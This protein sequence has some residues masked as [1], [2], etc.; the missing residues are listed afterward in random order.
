MKNVLKGLVALCCAVLGVEAVADGAS[1]N[2]NVIIIY[3]DDHGVTDLGLHGIDP[4]VD[5][6]TLDTLASGGALMTSGYASAPKC[7]PSRA[8]LMMGR[9]QNEVGLIINTDGPLPLT[10]P[11]GDPIVLIPERMRDLGYTTGQVGK[12]HLGDEGD[13]FTGAR[14]FDEYYTG[15]YT[16]YEVNFDLDGNSVP[17]QDVSHMRNRVTV[18]GEAAEA[19]I[20]RNH[21][22]EFFLYLAFYGPHTPRISTNDSYYVNFPELDYPNY[23]DEMD[24]I[25]RQGLALI[26]AIDDSVDGVMQKLREH[27]IEEDTL[28]FFAGDNGA[29]PKFGTDIGGVKSLETADGSE[30][31]PL[32]GEKGTLWEGGIRVPMFAYWKDTIPPGLVIDEPVSTLDFTATTLIAGG[33]TPTAEMDG[34]NLLPRLTNGAPT[35][36]RDTPLFW[37]HD[38]AIAIRKGDWKLQRDATADYLFNLADDPWELTNLRYQNPAK[39]AELVADLLAWRDSLPPEGQSTLG[40]PRGP[41]YVNGAPVGTAIE[42][43]YVIPYTNA[44]PAAYPVAIE[45]PGEPAL[46][47]DGDGML[48]D[49]EFAAGRDMNDASDLAFEFNADGDYQGW[50]SVMASISNATVTSGILS[51]QSESKSGRIESDD[52]SF[53]SGALSNLLV[54]VKSDASSTLTLR[55]ATSSNDV[56]DNTRK[57]AIPYSSGQFET[58]ILPLGGNPDWDG[59]T[60][61]RMRIN[62]CNGLGNF[63]IDWVRASDGDYDNDSLSDIYEQAN[64]LDPLDPSDGMPDTGGVSFTN[65]LIIFADDLGYGD[66]GCYGA[67][68]IATPHIDSLAANGMRFTQA[69]T[70]SSTCSQSRVSLFSGRY[71]WRSPLHPPTGVIHPAGP[72]ALLERGVVALPTLFQQKGYNTAAFGKWHLGVGYGDSYG[73]RYDWSQPTIEGGPLDVGFNHFFGLAANVLNEPD[74]YIENDKFYGR[75][76]NDVVTVN[77][78]N[79]V[80]PWSEDVRFAQDEVAGDTLAKAVEYIESAPTNEPLFLFFSST[81]PHKPITPAAEFIGSSGIGLYGDF[82]H[83]LDGQ[84]GA[85]LDAFRTT[86][87][88]DDTLVIFTSDNG[89]VI[90][91]SEASAIQWG[92]EPMWEA[93][94]AGHLS[95]G[96]LRGG[97]HA[98][99]EGGSRIPF[100][101]SWSNHIPANITDDR[102]FCLTDVMATCADLLDVSAPESAVDSL[103]FLPVW[104][105]ESAASPRDTVLT[106]SPSAIY[107]IR[108]EKW[109]YIEHDPDNPTGRVTENADQLYDLDLDPGESDNL[110]DQHPEIVAPLKDALIPLKA[111]LNEGIPFVVAP[112]V[113]GSQITLRHPVRQTYRYDILTSE[114]LTDP[115]WQEVSVELAASNGL[116][117]IVVEM[118]D[119]TNRFYVVKESSGGIGVEVWNDSFG[120]SLNTNWTEYLQG[121]GAATTPTGGQLVMDVGIP[122]GSAQ[123]A[124][125]TTV[126]QD[127]DVSMFNGAKL[128]NFYDHPVSARFD[129]ASI[130]GVN[131]GGRN[132]F[133]FSIGD[134]AAGKFNPQANALDDG[135]GFRLE[136]QG[137]P[138]SW[139]IIYQALQGAS[140][141][142]ATVANLNGLPST[143]TFTLDGTQAVIEL[144]GTT[145]TGGDSVLT[146]TLADYSANISGYTLAF[147]AL[148]YGTVTEKTVVTLDAVSVEVAE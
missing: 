107:S 56:M 8:G 104:T 1:R 37:D 124:L 60:I 21:T 29:C 69:Y 113:S 34:V 57:I 76:S 47:I 77:S 133:Y 20:D 42:P 110:F 6:P 120:G 98:V 15:V 146:Q 102:L 123:A 23:S 92:N 135:I 106:R 138:A 80:D 39:H 89:A 3:T 10:D 74:F 94:S 43:R 136:Q 49:D 62:P 87:R 11:E 145:S 126:N 82:L 128:Y 36:I 105:G 109:K 16:D 132:V 122:N 12:W 118:D 125:N 108:Q 137:D 31:V 9:I 22:N 79:S 18:Q 121:A 44:A 116:M 134:D 129:I 41:V 4:H 46:D 28:I 97:K 93:Y 147:G 55:W 13:H 52:F 144:E 131:G 32:R 99:F 63:E 53:D 73:E 114:S 7:V 26:K 2:P 35:V 24:V 139:R 91:T 83:E 81:V 54:R 78:A 127:G 58:V 61:S 67:T 117:E 33:G 115:D 101:V 103:S 100:I 45:T 64:G 27:G 140:A 71:W 85:L 70:P 66:V 59:Q 88:L 38:Q 17:R 14:G 40:N 25:R 119:A 5:T 65:V 19:F 86:G 48:N 112:S 51:G 84:V 96:E 50:D 141:S 148:N 30:N 143:I 72:N 75:G 130:T 111:A 142:S 68:N 90:S 95:N